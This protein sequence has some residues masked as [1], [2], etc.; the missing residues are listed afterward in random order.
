[1]EPGDIDIH[2]GQVWH[3]GPANKSPH[4]R[5]ALGVAFIADDT[6]LCLNPPGFCGPSGAGMRSST[7]TSLFGTNAE[8]TLVRGERH[9]LL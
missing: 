4:W 7:L 2:E 9:P 8:G 6:R 5:R 3:Y 1:M